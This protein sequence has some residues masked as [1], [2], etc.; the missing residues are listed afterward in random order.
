M[1][2]WISELVHLTV[3]QVQALPDLDNDAAMASHLVTEKLATKEQILRA[4]SR[5]Y[6][7]PSLTLSGYS[8]SAEAVSLLTEEEARKLLVMPL[9]C[10]QGKL[11]AAMSDP[12]D[13]R[14]EDF[15]RKLTGKRVKTVLAN[16]DDINAI[17]TRKYLTS[18][19]SGSTET[20]TLKPR[21]EPTQDHQPAPSN[22]TLAEEHS[23]VVKA[24]WRLLRQGIRLGASDIH[25][26]PEKEH[27]SLRYRIDGV[28]HSY[29]APA[30]SEYSAIVSRIKVI[31]MLDIAEKRLPQDGRVSISLE[32]EEYDLRVSILPNVHG[33][34]VCIRIL[35]SAAAS[36]KL[37]QMGF[38]EHVLR[39]FDEV[40]RLPY[41][42]VLVTGPT[43]SGK[44]TT[45]YASLS[46]IATRERKI[47]TVEDPVEYKL[48]GLQQVPIRPD[49]GYTF[50]VGLRAILRHDPD[51]IMLGEIR[52]LESAQIAFR[53]ALTG[54]LLF[55]TLHTNSAALAVSR[56]VDMGL[57]AYQ[58]M[59]G[60][61]GILGQRLIRVLCQACKK[62][63]RLDSALSKQLGLGTP[64]SKLL[65][66]EPVGCQQC[67]NLGYK[68]RT[69]IHEFLRI[70]PKM[71]H[72]KDSEINAGV[73]ESLAREDGFQTL[74][75]S[76]LTKLLDGI[77]SVNEVFA[78]TQG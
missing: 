74:R 16:V 25:L 5:F 14:C 24:V 36:R 28:L 66:Y 49:I 3:E 10:L 30:K 61:S 1:I 34:G 75:E 22:R 23:P 52:D 55:S 71:K 7:L 69:G 67:D 78:A 31:S 56:L 43:G 51:V 6:R 21:T 29:D 57:P 15:L 8:P 63:A 62:E 12:N 33:E 45:L 58:V 32:D 37:E 48:E 65:V 35:D 53:A 18:Q 4:K 39:R 73:L 60:L 40:I 13:L 41:G 54:H 44:S 50:G 47:I 59:A 26:E 27:V 19:D 2:P 20:R 42:I 64:D 68:G 70:T 77:T 38:Q 46:R 72:L 17:I 76:A 9:F 11:Y